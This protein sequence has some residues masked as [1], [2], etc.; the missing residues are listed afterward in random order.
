LR[1]IALLLA[2]IVV[3]SACAKTSPGSNTRPIDV[4]AA[5]PSVS[6][7][8]SM[9]GDRNWWVG[10]PSFGVP[11]L[12]A[13]M[14]PFQVRFSITQRFTNVGTSEALIVRYTMYDKGSSATTRMS[15]IQAA[16]GTSL[17]GAKVGDQV[18]Y[19]GQAAAGGAP[20]GTA[21]FVRVGPAVVAISW[22]RKDGYPS[23]TQ[24]GKIATKVVARLKD[25]LNGKSHGKPI[26]SAD[27]A[28]LPPPGP[29]ITLLGSARIPVE[30]MADMLNVA[31]PTDLVNVFHSLGVTDFVFG[32]YALDRDL[33]MEVRAAEFSFATAADATSWIDSLVGKSSVD[34]NG[35]YVAY[36][37]P[38][39]EYYNILTVGARGAILICRS[40]TDLEAASRAC[41]TPLG[42]VLGAW[43]QA[44]A[45]A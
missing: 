32:D 45:T 19:Y 34:S 42:R 2:G 9:L 25:V 6:D 10:P 39:G 13:A 15:N 35:E 24:L 11:P 36:N 4:Y 28:L 20:F 1:S 23:I 37:D 29:D 40:T 31:S 33:H 5:V 26:S 7:V 17:T 22:T 16:L 43:K 27:D 14:T 21:T 8:S 44:L 12:D 41:E 38:T 30:A 18:L 3:L